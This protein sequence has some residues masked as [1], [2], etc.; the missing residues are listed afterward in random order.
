[1]GRLFFAT[2]L[3]ASRELPGSLEMACLLFAFPHQ[4]LDCNAVVQRISGNDPGRGIDDRACF[5]VTTPQSFG[6]AAGRQSGIFL[7][8]TAIGPVEVY[9]VFV[10]AFDVETAFVH[11]P[12]VMT[13]EQN[14]IVDRGVATI[15]PVPNVMRIDEA[16]VSAA[17]EAAATVACL[18]GST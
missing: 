2:I 5:T 9:A 10:G 6:A 18:Q 11:K 3:P 1:M 16:V 17:R 13:A 8:D 7:D 4:S 14:E 12:V 15:R